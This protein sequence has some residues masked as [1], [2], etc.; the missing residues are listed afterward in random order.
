MSDILRT[1]QSTSGEWLGWKETKEG[2][3]G[4][5][6]GNGKGRDGVDREGLTRGKYKAD[7]GEEGRRGKVVMHG[8][9]WERGRIRK[10]CRGKYIRRG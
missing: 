6:M 10:G 3:G 5:G 4:E 9:G 2:W 1:V 8:T 7:E